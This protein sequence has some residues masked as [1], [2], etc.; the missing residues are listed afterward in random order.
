MWISGLLHYFLVFFEDFMAK[1]GQIA[2]YDGGKGIKIFCVCL[3]AFVFV[4]ALALI[5]LGNFISSSQT[6]F[7]DY[8]VVI[9]A[10]HGDIDG[11]VVGKT[12]G[13]KESELNLKMAYLLKEEFE[14]CGIKVVLTRTD[15]NGLYGEATDGFKKRDMAKR[16]EIILDAK[17]DMVISVHM[18]KFSSSSRS[19]P[20]VFFDQNSEA[21][22]KLAT[23]IQT[24]LNAF[25]G[26]S[27]AALKG[28]YYMLKCT[29]SPSVIVECGF[30]S[31]P[32]EEQQLLDETYRKKLA[33]KIFEG[34]LL[35]MS[36]SGIDS[37][38]VV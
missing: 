10:G 19:G 13:V 38:D 17:A 32:Y 26:N 15:E 37:G 5:F 2:G 29:T 27:H 4:S 36:Y 9:D 12:S 31:N 1:R 30:L 8:V 11:G 34:A 25:T 22:Q 3:A 24:S 7:F 18:N 14:T 21:G 35:F 6:Q 33:R 28:D 20:Q 23:R 16:K